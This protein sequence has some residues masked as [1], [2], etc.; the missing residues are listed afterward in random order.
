MSNNKTK[1]ADLAMVLDRLSQVIATLA[2]SRTSTETD[3]KTTETFVF[4]QVSKYNGE[5]VKA[6]IN[7]VRSAFKA[8]GKAHFL[9]H[10]IQPAD[11]E[12]GEYCRFY[13]LMI[14]TFTH[15]TIELIQHC[16]TVFAIWSLFE[17]SPRC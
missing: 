8:C 2:S 14:L 11:P 4:G 10:E 1:D 15:N 13:G 6:W 16:K 7:T 3:S 5:N 9:D 17:S 12:Y